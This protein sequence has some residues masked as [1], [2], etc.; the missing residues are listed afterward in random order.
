MAGSSKIGGWAFI[1]GVLL[2]VIFGF[3]GTSASFSWLLLILG[4]I[5]GLLNITDKETQPFLLAG[6]V[7]VIVGQFGGS[8]FSSVPGIGG[9]FNALI[10]LFAPATV[11]VALK[12]VFM[13]AK[14]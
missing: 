5:V 4:L 8:V 6:V 13:I 1:I 10:Q 14:K 7:L 12:S 9:I 11:I 2:A 3:L